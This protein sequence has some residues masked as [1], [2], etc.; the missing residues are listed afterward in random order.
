M[1]SF[2][3]KT[4]CGG[5]A[6]GSA[7]VFNR[8]RK[9]EAGHKAEDTAEE[10]KRL[11][12]AVCNAKEQLIGFAEESE[13]ETAKD[14]FEIHLMML[15]DDDVL[16]SLRSAVTDDNL[17][18]EKAVART[19]EYFSQLFYNTQDEC[20]MARI[21]DIRDVC[22]RLLSFLS[23]DT[24]SEKPQGSFV[25]VANELLP[26]DLMRLKCDDLIGIV[27][28][29]GSVY[30][31]VSILI[32]EMAIPAVICD[33]VKNIKTG[34][35]VLLNA[36]S[37]DVIFEPDVRAEDDFQSV[38]MEVKK[39]VGLF[40][41]LPFGVYVNIGDPKE[42]SKELMAKCD[43]IGLF[44]TEYMYFGRPELPGEEEQFYVYKDILEKADGKP[45]TI[46][47]FDIGSDK[48]VEALPLK[49]EENPAL[50]F[51]GIR[52]Y[53]VYPDVFKTQIKALL[54]AAVYGNLRVMY[55]MV[56]SC[57]DVEEI[58]R[59]AAQ[60]EKELAEKNIPYRIPIRGAMIETPAAALSADKLAVNVDFF[61]IGTNDL[62]QYTYAVDR[63][64][65]RIARFVDPDYDALFTLIT[66]VSE[67]ARKK[68]IET[69]ICGELASDT[70]LLKKWSEAGIDY[71]SVS[72]SLLAD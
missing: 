34:M 23:E 50:G 36:D 62:V 11:E 1:I 28:A 26:S 19:E 30:S 59:I 2:H 33:D 46:R 53:S 65:G 68:G 52:V 51:R 27:T 44:R 57:G 3:G 70:D 29:S 37:G 69:G 61:S 39:K 35:R 42:V 72:P 17:T 67:A 31:H 5:A 60:A 12:V 4:V 48:S 7:Y 40:E 38:I 58:N 43:G 71:I 24:L 6:A 22:G 47:T 14:I 13:N 16:D 49:N 18:A 45:V 66:A 8:D 41:N 20:M 64:D 56:N 10:L 54:R 9:P 63:Q 32:K 55:P 25:I 21:D 15:E